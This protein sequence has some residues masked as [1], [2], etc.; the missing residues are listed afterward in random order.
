MT[1]DNDRKAIIR[2]RMRKT[3][4]SYTAARAHV[5]ANASRPQPSAAYTDYSARAGKSDDKVRA[6]TGRTW[7]EWVELLDRE[8]AGALRHR[9]VARALEQKHGLSD[10]WAQTVT[11][12][13]ERIK[14]VREI[15][16]RLTGTYEVNRSRTFDV[17]VGVLFDAFAKPALR[18]RWLTD[19]S[20]VVRTAAP[21]KTMRLQWPDGTIVVLGFVARTDRK[22]TVSVQH[23]KLPDRAAAQRAKEEWAARFDA[24]GS[25]LARR[26]RGV[27][28]PALHRAT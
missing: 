28:R 1:R 16:Q 25:A 6:A 26:G 2:T 4:E 27:P 15:G 14:G 24:L 17:P 13:Y 10:W 18:R 9:D 3:G 5:I 22:A 11:V 21:P 7:R 20:P 23:T 8:N 12:G 19:A